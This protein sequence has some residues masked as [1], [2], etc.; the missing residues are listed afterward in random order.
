LTNASSYTG[1]HIGDCD[2]QLP[3][4]ETFAGALTLPESIFNL[5]NIIMGVGVISVPYAFKQ[6]GYSVLLLLLVVT[7]IAQRTAKWIGSSLELAAKSTEAKLVALNARDFA[8]LAQLAFGGRGATF[9]NVVTVFE[10]WSALVTFMVMNGTNA[11]I[12]WPSLSS[13][14]CVTVTCICATFLCFIPDRLFS[15][16]SLMSTAA[17]LAAAVTLV[18]SALM[19]PTWDEPPESQSFL[20]VDNIPRSVGIIIFCF[21]GHPCFPAVHSSMRE[22]PKWSRAVNCSF[23]VAFLYY[24][25]MGFFGYIVFGSKLRQSITENIAGIKGA[26]F[27]QDVAAVCFLVKVEFT[28]PLLLNAVMVAVWPPE[29]GR[30]LWTAPRVCLTFAVSAF[31]T[32]VAVWLADAL[33]IVASL[34]GNLFVMTTSVLFP[35]LLHMALTRRFGE[36]GEPRL[37]S[38]IQYGAVLSF[39]TVMAITG[40]Y[41]A[42]KDLMSK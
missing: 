36:P 12:L 13:A 31:T 20:F 15:Y 16:L 34:T 23:V 41:L 17:L 6:T 19:L 25:M 8:F 1:A 22:K 24:G 4:S 11:N 32:L 18:A 7:G 35:A 42:V 10:I 30:A 14:L 26:L 21:A 2:F 33:A 9:I 29:I 28:V 27:W 38:Y 37:S 3:Q 5:I 40:T 39:G